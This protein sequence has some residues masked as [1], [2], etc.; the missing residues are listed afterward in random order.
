MRSKF[1]MLICYEELIAMVSLK[2]SLSRD[3][4]ELVV[5]TVI[6]AAF[7]LT[8]DDVASSL[9]RLDAISKKLNESVKCLSNED[10]YAKS[11]LQ[12]L[13]NQILEEL[14]ELRRLT[15]STER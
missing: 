12:V 8:G 2:L 15:P 7:L 4:A 13:T 10:Y 1:Y 14:E 9:N 6:D 3:N 5:R 11:N